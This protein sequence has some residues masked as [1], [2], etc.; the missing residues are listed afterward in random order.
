VRGEG[1][2]QEL[3][4]EAPVSVQEDH[5]L[6]SEGSEAS[7]LETATEWPLLQVKTTLLACTAMYPRA[8]SEV[9]KNASKVP[10]KVSAFPKDSHKP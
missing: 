8:N 9:H 7:T 3:L 5:P 4:A 10:G 6:P 2:Q 1:N